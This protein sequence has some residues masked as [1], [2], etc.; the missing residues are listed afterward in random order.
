MANKAGVPGSL[1]RKIFRR[2]NYACRECGLTGREVRY[3]SGAFVFPTDRKGVY[4]SIDHVIPRF[5]GGTSAPE[6]LRVLCTVCNT[7]KGTK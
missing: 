5:R 3:P 2:D 4:L 7:R 6:N 1:R